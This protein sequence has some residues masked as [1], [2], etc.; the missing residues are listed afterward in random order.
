[1][2]WRFCDSI[3]SGMDEHYGSDWFVAVRN[4]EIQ[5]YSKDVVNSSYAMQMH[6][7]IECVLRSDGLCHFNLMSGKHQKC[8]THFV[9]VVQVFHD[10]FRSMLWK[11]GEHVKISTHASNRT[12]NECSCALFMYGTRTRWKIENDKQ[13]R[14]EKEIIGWQNSKCSVARTL[15]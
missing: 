2:R 14:T 12:N 15:W 7:Q 9:A 1:M 5:C 4:G 11:N 8:T 6:A 13:I 10:K 3:V